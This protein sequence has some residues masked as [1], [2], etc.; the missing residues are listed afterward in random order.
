ME[1][2][3]RRILKYK[4]F[5]LIIMCLTIFSAI[6]VA[7]WH[8]G[9][10]KEIKDKYFKEKE[11]TS[12]ATPSV[13]IATIDGA[14]PTNTH[15]TMET[16]IVDITT[17]EITT[18]E[19]TI[20]ETTTAVQNVTTQ[21]PTTK[22]VNNTT[23]QSTDI[24]LKGKFTAQFKSVNSWDGHCQYELTVNNVSAVNIASWKI[25]TKLPSDSSISSSWNCVCSIEGDTLIVSPMDYNSVID[26][27]KSVDNIGIIVE[28]SNLPSTIDYTGTASGSVSSGNSDVSV[29][30]STTAS[31]TPETNYDSYTPP[32]LESG[33]PLSNHGKLA[34]KGTDLVDNNGNKFQLK[35]VSTHG[36]TWFPQY[37]NK[38]AFKTIRDD[39]GA[40]TVRLALYTAEYNGYCSGGNQTELKKIV[41]N[42]V[43]YATELGM[44]VIIDW[45]ILSDGNPN[46]NKAAALV[47]FAEMA[48]KYKDYNNV[49]YEICNEPNDGVDWSTVKGYADDVI[50]VI[51]KY[52]SDAIILVGT[53]TWSQEVDKVAANPVENSHNVMYVLHFYAATHKDDLRNRLKSA[54]AAGTPVFISEF[55]ICDAS[56]NGGI[57]YTSAK[58]WKELIN[59]YN[60]SYIGWNLSNKAETSS[61]I[62]S[63]CSKTSGW[64]MAEL[65]ETGKWLRNFIA[66]Y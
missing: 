19:I 66:G 60:I 44:Y 49:I 57:D 5:F 37:V 2:D 47:F 11:T 64:T 16:V 53:P 54:V 15:V 8:T 43:S 14:V 58:A 59:S 38:E 1:Q 17:S 46:T 26:A 65:T 10:L 51:R 36:I 12:K 50:K 6:F 63:S 52:D 9:A 27:G 7:F 21:V 13:V 22:P 48:Q 18:D 32:K 29:Q 39:W 35:G 30:Q 20:V 31:N 23:T 28:G 42:G 40:N 62:N 4:I 34:V 41:E 3:K 56:G 24:S 33:T 55:S 45:H 61:L 25:S